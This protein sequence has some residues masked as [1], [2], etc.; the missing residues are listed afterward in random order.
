LIDVYGSLTGFSK[1]VSE[2]CPYFASLKFKAASD[3]LTSL[4]QQ[5]DER[6]KVLLHAPRGKHM[7][8]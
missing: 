6:L 2:F 8:G 1:F 3:A 5:A 4:A 7:G